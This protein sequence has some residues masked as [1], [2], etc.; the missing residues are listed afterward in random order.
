MRAFVSWS[1]GKDT[2]LAC[3]QALRHGNLR[4]DYL[5]NMARED[6]QYSRSHGIPSAL[7]KA[8]SEALE[9]PLVQA[10]ASWESYTSVFVQMLKTLQAQGIEAGIFGDIDIQEHREWVERVCQTAGIRPILPLWQ[11]AREGLLQQF[12]RAGFKAVIVAVWSE[13]LGQE[14]LGRK[15]DEALLCDLKQVPDVDLCGE[16]GEY[17]TFI[18]AGPLFKRQV[19]FTAGPGRL[20]NKHWFLEL[21]PGKA[22]E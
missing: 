2:A 16:S 18:Y 15:I 5:L 1:G 4:I 10:R 7:I 13:R 17:H 8:Q 14:W 9:I 19:E 6:G 20:H 3:Y 12:I 11:Q 21:K 22:K